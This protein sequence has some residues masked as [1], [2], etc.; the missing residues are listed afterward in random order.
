M[1]KAPI[2]NVM[3]THRHHEKGSTLVCALCIILIM[4]FIGANVL[5]NCTT[6]YNVTSAL[7]GRVPMP[8]R[9]LGPTQCQTHSEQRAI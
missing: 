6:R 8:P 4:S 3:N 5:M 2:F 9:G 7:V 1:T